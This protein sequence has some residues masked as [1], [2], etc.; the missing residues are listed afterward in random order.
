VQQPTTQTIYDLFNGR[1]QFIVPVYQR[2]YIWNAWDNWG[3]LWDD[4]ADTAE[5]YITDPTAQ[6]PSRH[7]LGP[8]VLDQQ[9]FEAGGVDPRLVI[10][11][12]QRLTTLQIILSAAAHVAKDCGA[13]EVARELAELTFNRGRAA[14]GNLRF[15]VWPSRRDR[16]AF[17]HVMEK[18]AAANGAGIPGAWCYFRDRIE[19]WV[20]DEGEADK[21][22]QAERIEA[23]QT[24]LDSL[25]YVV[26]INLDESDNAQ[27]IFETLN[28][29][30]TGLGALDLVKNAT[31]LQ[32]ERDQAPAQML[33]DE[34]WEPTFEK[35]DYWLEEVRQGRERRARAD[36]FLMHWL[37]ME[38]GQVVRSDKLFDTFR[39]DILRGPSAL[40]M[41]Q[42]IPQLC[43]D[44]RLMRSFDDFEPGTP[45]GLF[46]SRLEAMDTTTMLPIVLLLFRSDEL[47]HRR[48]RRA[49]AALESWLVR[50]A[51]LRLTAK[52]YNRTLT[53]LLTAIKADIARADEAVV[54]ELRSSQ[55]TTAVW[56]PDDEI[57]WRLEEGDLYGYVGQARVRMLL[58]ACELDLRDPAKTEA[59]AIP[60]G[61]SIEHA[62]PQLWEDH[63]PLP[64]GDDPEV[65][66]S[67]RDAHVNRLG[68]LTLVTQPLNAAMSN[69][70]WCP[71]E[72]SPYSK[73]AELAKR[74]VLLINQHLCQ[75]DHWSEDLIDQRGR[76]LTDRIIRTWPGPDASAWA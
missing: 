13:G 4:I 33:H 60:A 46:F 17:L 10:D 24:C 69:S 14:T 35:D 56:P 43:D 21:D 34:Y 30:G 51:I 25:L 54:R 48:R 31:F 74:S 28:A 26:S 70:S 52:N 1:I 41:V 66:R 27:V 3:V 20:T 40:P 61:L 59:I 53:S 45:E 50:R 57:R 72:T 62:L 15:K 6:V 23:L 71:S 7:F 49:L 68:N 75:N 63:W 37:A 8:I 18:G 73:R 16:K 64:P 5:R 42:L 38:L 58:E 22:R 12:Q 65:L 76:E 29:R 47:G 39:K 44:A 19:E 32:A 11:G 36:W 67:N 55:A 2:A 9:H